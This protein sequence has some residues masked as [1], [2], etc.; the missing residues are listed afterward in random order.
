[1]LAGS[2]GPGGIHFDDPSIARSIG[3][4]ALALILFAGGL[5]TNWKSVQPVLWQGL[6]LSTVAVFI[7]ALLVGWFVSAVT[8][9]SLLEGL[10][11]GSIVSSTDAAAVFAVLRS[12]SVSL[13]GNLK[14]LL[15]LE[16]GSNDPMAVF[17]TTG[18]IGLIANPASSFAG[19]IP[20]FIQQMTLGALIGYGAG[21]MMIYIIN[22]LRLEYEGLYPV[23]TLALVL[24]SYSGA[25]IVGGNGFL[26]VY[27]AGIIMGNN[28]FIHKRSL[29][30]FHDGL[31]WLMQITMFLALGLLV[32][33]SHILPI[34]GI[35]FLVAAFLM[36]VA[37]P[38]SV[39]ATLAF[40]KTN[41]R[42]KT[43]VSWV[44]LRGAVPIILATFPLLAGIRQADMIF[45]L[46]FF[47]VLTSALL[48]GSSIP[49]VAK[50]LR[51]DAPLPGDTEAAYDMGEEECIICRLAE[52]RV[53]EDSEL[54]GKQIVEAG[55]PENTDIV[56]LNRGRRII[57]PTGAT[58]LEPGDVMLV[59]ADEES[60]K[61]LKDMLRT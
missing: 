22:H 19:L 37:R 11:L 60:L 28:D 20:M 46:V 15:E 52:V 42:E 7:T 33:P 3:V 26:A 5:D 57:I 14:P 4:V 23:L 36:I 21:R 38:V 1:M 41:T 30:R 2:E 34:I 45:N 18:F 58:I 56:L 32:F 8:P 16:S 27:I 31:A 12:R 50:W 55:L 51:V 24:I 25:S 6:G 59:L 53:P 49:K 13:R 54:I 35:G 29:V 9:F 48:Q 43:L 47:I 10:L 40:A 17:L 39:F 44:G 61:R